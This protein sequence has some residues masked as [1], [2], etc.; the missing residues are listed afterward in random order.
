MAPGK[1]L[2]YGPSQRWQGS[3][4]ELA[5]HHK[6]IEK[7][8]GWSIKKLRWYGKWKREGKCIDWQ[9]VIPWLV[10]IESGSE[11]HF[12]TLLEVYLMT[13]NYRFH[14]NKRGLT[15]R[16]ELLVSRTCLSDVTTGNICTNKCCKEIFFSTFGGKNKIDIDI[17]HRQNRCYC[18]ENDISTSSNMKLKTIS[19]KQYSCCKILSKNFPGKLMSPYF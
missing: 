3:P 16:W 2:L 14:I 18:R 17:K 13:F 19:K 1:P 4:L 8:E 12:L 9:K 11:H 6:K 15:W 5:A 10:S 7:K